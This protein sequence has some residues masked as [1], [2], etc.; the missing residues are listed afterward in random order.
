[1]DVKEIFTEI[2]R[3]NLSIFYGIYRNKSQ[4]TWQYDMR[5]FILF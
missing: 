2:Y 1:M 4:Q 5:W 3:N